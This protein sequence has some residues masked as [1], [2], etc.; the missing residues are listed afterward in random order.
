MGSKNIWVRRNLKLIMKSPIKMFILYFYIF[1]KIIPIKEFQL[2]K[3]TGSEEHVL[4]QALSSISCLM[5]Y[6]HCTGPGP[7]QVQG[8]G[9]GAMGLNILY[10]SVPTSKTWKGTR[11]HCLLLCSSRYLIPIQVPV[12]CSVDKPLVPVFFFQ[13]PLWDRILAIVSLY[14]ASIYNV[15][16]IST[17]V[18]MCKL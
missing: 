6:S 11:T 14:R 15:P 1:Q 7:E 2:L 9:L 18:L 12:R 16:E 8:M 10:R 4:Q 3:L 5:A 17:L 13:I